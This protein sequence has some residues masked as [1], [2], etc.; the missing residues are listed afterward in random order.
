MCLMKEIP[1]QYQA[2]HILDLTQAEV[3]E[4]YNALCI[5]R[6]ESREMDDKVSF[7]LAERLYPLH[8]RH[9]PKAEC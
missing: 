6:G 1:R 5:V 4:I 7:D 8:M 3:N 2:K 9:T